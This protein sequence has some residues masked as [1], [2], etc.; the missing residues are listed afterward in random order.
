MYTRKQKTKRCRHTKTTAP[1][2]APSQSTKSSIDKEPS[3]IYNLTQFQN[4]YKKKLFKEWSKH[5]QLSKALLFLSLQIDQKRHNGA[6]FQAFFLFLPIGKPPQ[7]K[8]KPLTEEWITYWTLNKAKISCHNIRAFGQWRRI[9]T[10]FMLLHALLLS[11]V[12]VIDLCLW[13]IK[14]WLVKCVVYYFSFFYP[15]H[16]S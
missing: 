10:L 5:S 8:S 3:P 12:N 2:G 11:V 15:Y 1:Y 7:L 13:K 6:T 14:S 16:V 9:W 4:R